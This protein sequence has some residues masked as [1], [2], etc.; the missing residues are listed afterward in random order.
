MRLYRLVNTIFDILKACQKILS[1][2]KHVFIKI[3]ISTNKKK[4]TKTTV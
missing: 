4:K 3:A 1:P 2:S